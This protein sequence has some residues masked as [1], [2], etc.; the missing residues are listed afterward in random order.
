M[1]NADA[2]DSLGPLGSLQI[3]RE[4]AAEQ[5][6]DAIREAILL[7]E[8]DQ[9]YRLNEAALASSIGVARNTVREAMHLLRREGLVTSQMHKGTVV[10]RLDAN[11]VRDI[12]RVRK[13]LEIAGLDFIPKAAPD[14]VVRLS[15]AVSKFEVAAEGG[16]WA[17]MVDADLLFHANLV[18]ALGSERLNRFFDG[19]Q[20]EVRLCMS[21]VDRSSSTLAEIVVE[22]QEMM[23]LILNKD[24]KGCSK[25]LNGHLTDAERLLSQFVVTSTP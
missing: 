14:N 25:V 11:D 3:K 20:A 6:A 23:R 13:L 21:I 8:I 1:A 12:F 9:G 5:V 16:N 4:R 19:I 10:T 24:F 22:H 2:A 7:G 15:E 17:E 18:G